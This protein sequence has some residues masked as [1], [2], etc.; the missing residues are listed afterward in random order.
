MLEYVLGENCKSN[1]LKLGALKNGV[2]AFLSVG[3]VSAGTWSASENNPC[4]SCRGKL[5]CL[6]GKNTRTFSLQNL[7]EMVSTCLYICVSNFSQIN[8]LFSANLFQQ[9]VMCLFVIRPL[10]GT[11]SSKS[12]ANDSGITSSRSQ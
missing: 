6:V 8:R 10:D 3:R 12:H 2:T 11:R 7:Q 9:L 4:Y 1:V 5:S